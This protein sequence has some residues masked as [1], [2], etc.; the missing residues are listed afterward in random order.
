MQCTVYT[1]CAHTVLYRVISAYRASKPRDTQ[2]PLSRVPRLSVFVAESKP[3][4]LSPAMPRSFLVKSKRAGSYSLRPLEAGPGSTA[5]T[6]RTGQ[7]CG[8]S[9][10]P[11]SLGPPPPNAVEPQCRETPAPCPRHTLQLPGSVTDGDQQPVWSPGTETEAHTILL[12]PS[13]YLF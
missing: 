5:S 1:E 3:S 7:P 2:C 10:G 13:K 12:S 8:L 4:A 11:Q 9:A 6:L